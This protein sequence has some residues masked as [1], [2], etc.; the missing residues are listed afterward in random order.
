MASPLHRH[1]SS[2]EK[3]IDFSTQPPLS[4]R[5]KVKTTLS[6]LLAYCSRTA[7]PRKYNWVS[8]LE[9]VQEYSISEL[10]LDNF[11]RYI[12]TSILGD[13]PEQ[14]IDLVDISTKFDNFD[15]WDEIHKDRI[16]KCLQEIADNLVNCFFLPCMRETFCDSIIILTRCLVRAVGSKTPQPSHSLTPTVPGS[17]RLSPTGVTYRLSNLRTK[18]L[19]RD[20]HRCVITRRFD[21]SEAE[22][23]YKLD[24]LEARDDDGCVLASEKEAPTFL[25]VSHIIPHS[26]MSIGASSNVGLVRP[27]EFLFSQPKR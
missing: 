9:L 18:C 3:I 20:R 13:E 11:L 17:A 8:L 12:F 15:D 5:A 25:E 14:R 16:S 22:S 21:R 2:L 4:N 10:G 27:T 6:Q 23:R 26:L 1:Q 7:E 19:T 24:G